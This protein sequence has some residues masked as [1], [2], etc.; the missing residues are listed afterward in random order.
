MCAIQFVISNLLN[1]ENAVWI[2]ITY[3]HMYVGIPVYILY[4]TQ[5]EIKKYQ[6]S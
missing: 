2:Y 5:H 1:T 4:Y 3:I 6:K